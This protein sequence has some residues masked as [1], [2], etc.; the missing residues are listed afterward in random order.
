MYVC[1][2]VLC[3]YIL[4]MYVCMYVCMHVCTMYVC[5]HVW[6][7]SGLEI[8]TEYIFKVQAESADGTSIESETGGKPGFEKHV[9]Y[10]CEVRKQVVLISKTQQLPQQLSPEEEKEWWK[11]FISMILMNYLIHY[12]MLNFNTTL[13]NLFSFS[14]ISWLMHYLL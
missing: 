3:M 6:S 7:I 14:V 1:M 4:C 5:M 12:H 11:K 2:Y 10:Y 13:S 8:S 9:H